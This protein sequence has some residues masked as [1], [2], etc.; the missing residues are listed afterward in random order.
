MKKAAVATTT[1]KG[2]AVNSSRITAVQS[3]YIPLMARSFPSSQFLTLFLIG[4]GS[5]PGWAGVQFENCQRG[6]DGSISCDTVPTGDTLVRD[7]AARFG[8]FRNASPGWTDFEPFQATDEELG[9]DG[10]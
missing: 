5:A 1:A 6:V 2:A 3:V 7:Q 9:G 4:M 10:D 8:L